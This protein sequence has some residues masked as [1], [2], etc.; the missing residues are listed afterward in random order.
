MSDIT[1]IGPG[2]LSAIF[3]VAIAAFGIVLVGH[4]PTWPIY[5]TILM[6]VGFILYRAIR[7]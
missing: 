6:W 3:L 5:V 1:K 7:S 4:A 2:W